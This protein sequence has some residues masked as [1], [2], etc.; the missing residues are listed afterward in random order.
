MIIPIKYAKHFSRER[1]AEYCTNYA[2]IFKRQLGNNAPSIQITPE[3]VIYS[4]KEAKQTFLPLESEIIEDSIIK[5]VQS[6]LNHYIKQKTAFCRNGIAYIPILKLGDVE[7]GKIKNLILE[8]TESE[9]E[10]EE[11]S[12]SFIYLYGLYSETAH[13]LSWKLYKKF[14]GGLDEFLDILSRLNGIS[15]D[16]ETICQL[17]NKNSKNYS[18]LKQQKRTEYINGILFMMP[19]LDALLFDGD[20]CAKQKLI[21]GGLCKN[22]KDDLEAG[23]DVLREEFIISGHY[24]GKKLFSVMYDK[25]NHNLNEVYK[26]ANELLSNPE[27]QTPKDFLREIGFSEEELWLYNGILNTDYMDMRKFRIT[28]PKRFYEFYTGLHRKVLE[29]AK[30]FLE[31]ENS[32]NI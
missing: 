2:N 29:S 12:T 3:E 19:Y 10:Y 25:L 13:L 1:L 8:I 23:L 14:Y 11:L 28:D 5:S 21:E 26:E 18:Q 24:D 7:G 6:I 20:E 17:V 16:I 31:N 32:G 9:R 4:T 15:L 30:Q 27:I 22:E